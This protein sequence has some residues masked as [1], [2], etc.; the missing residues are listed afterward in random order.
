[1]RRRRISACALTILVVPL[2]CV[3]QAA[4]A[5]PIVAAAGDIACAHDDSHYN[6]G[7]GSPGFCRQRATS[8][9]MVGAGLAAVLPLGDIQYDSASATDLNLV[10][11]PT[12]GRIKAISRPVLGN[13][14]GAGADY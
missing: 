5:D 4:A 11:D 8:D 6:G 13:H 12:W 14:E 3:G 1:M 10:Y 2:A 9:V 7:A